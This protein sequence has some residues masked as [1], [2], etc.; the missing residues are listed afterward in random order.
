MK[1]I[2]MLIKSIKQKSRFIKITILMRGDLIGVFDNSPTSHYIRL[3]GI[4]VTY[5]DK[6]YNVED[7]YTDKK[8]IYWEA[9]N[10]Y[11]LKSR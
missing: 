2:L 11:V 1:Y 4:I 6:I 3:T 9:D 10:P 8:Y 5:N 7:F